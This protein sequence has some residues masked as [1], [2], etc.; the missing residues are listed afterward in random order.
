M[1]PWQACVITLLFLNILI[2]HDAQV[3]LIALEMDAVLVFSVNVAIYIKKWPRIDHLGVIFSFNF[4]FPPQ[5]R[6]LFK[7]KTS[8]SIIYPKISI[9]TFLFF[10]LSILIW[11]YYVRKF[12]LEDVFTIELSIT[13]LG[14]MPIK[15]Y[16]T[17]LFYL[18]MF[19]PFFGAGG[20]ICLHLHR[21]VSRL[22]WQQFSHL[23]F[24]FQLVFKIQGRIF[25]FNF[26]SIIYL[27]IWSSSSDRRYNWFP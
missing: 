14:E 25:F 8:Q 1:Y 3:V 4:I 23:S 5:S 12:C 21:V 15:A 9:F 2:F 27:S 16:I 7:C 19:H 26:I 20:E 11:I 6:W 24:F 17:F 22:T 13:C 10:F 18:I